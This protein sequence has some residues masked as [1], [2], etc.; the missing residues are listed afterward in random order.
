VSA[1]G[2]FSK[3]RW[4]TPVFRDG[5][6]IFSVDPPTFP[7]RPTTSTIS[8]NPASWRGVSRIRWKFLWFFAFYP[9][10]T[11]P[12]YGGCCGYRINHT[13]LARWR[14]APRQRRRPMPQV[15]IEPMAA[16]GGPCS[17]CDPPAI[18]R[19]ALLSLKAFDAKGTGGDHQ[20]H[21]TRARIKTE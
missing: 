9:A 6:A 19:T 15:G 18:R 11:P 7:R 21:G 1:A 13:L 8:A 12:W 3:F 10:Q 4:D 5:R 14:K 2:C 16:P 20:S 17:L